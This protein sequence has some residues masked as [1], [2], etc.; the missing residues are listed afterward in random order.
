VMYFAEENGWKKEELS[1]KWSVFI[2]EFKKKQEL[3]QNQEK[4]LEKFVK[5]YGIN[6]IPVYS[7][8][9]SVA[10]QEF[11]KVVGRSQEPGIGWFCYDSEEGYGKFE[12]N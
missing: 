10:S 12:K 6:F 5:I 7:V 1:E 8:V 2:E 9:G 4:F 11:I 3:T